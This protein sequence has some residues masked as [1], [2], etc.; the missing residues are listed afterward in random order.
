MFTVSY[1]REAAASHEVCQAVIADWTVPMHPWRIHD[2]RQREHRCD[3]GRNPEQAAAL[4]SV[5]RHVP[6][7]K[8]GNGAR[9]GCVVI[10]T[11]ILAA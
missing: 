4:G 7:R 9:Q 6:H 1:L 11:A 3:V 10:V 8:S 5:I 2:T